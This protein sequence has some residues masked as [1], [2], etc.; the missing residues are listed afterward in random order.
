MVTKSLSITLIICLT[1]TT[2]ATPALALPS[3]IAETSSPLRAIW[4]DGVDAARRL[5]K[6]DLT[7]PVDFLDRAAP[8]LLSPEAQSYTTTILSAFQAAQAEGGMEEF[9]Q[10][11]GNAF[12]LFSAI[13]ILGGIQFVVTG[14]DVSEGLVSI[15]LGIMFFIFGIMILSELDDAEEPSP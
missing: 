7:A 1:I 3:R 5:H 4:V 2:A 12:L 8:W 15:I 9:L 14:E 13:M 11:I 6:G 10:Y